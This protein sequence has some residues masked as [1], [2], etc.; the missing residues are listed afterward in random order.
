M[1][2]AQSDKVK[3]IFMQ[4]GRFDILKVHRDYAMIERVLLAKVKNG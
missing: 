2:F 3:K 4:G 1:G